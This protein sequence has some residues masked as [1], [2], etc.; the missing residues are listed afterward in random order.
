VSRHIDLISLHE[1]MA[2]RDSDAVESMREKGEGSLSAIGK[3]EIEPE[4]RDRRHFVAGGAYELELAVCARDVDATFYVAEVHYDGKW[5]SGPD[6]W[7]HLRLEGLSAG[8]GKR[9]ARFSRRR[10][11]EH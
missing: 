8:R 4:P 7:R 2:L 10:D 11:G 9:R 5:R 3:L 1:P 6:I